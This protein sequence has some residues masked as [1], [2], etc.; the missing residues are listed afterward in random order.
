MI[1]ERVFERVLKPANQKTRKYAN[2]DRSNGNENQT[3]WQEA[4]LSGAAKA[5]HG[6]IP[7]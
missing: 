6:W 2:A 1:M 4:Y 7:G 5:Q 3:C